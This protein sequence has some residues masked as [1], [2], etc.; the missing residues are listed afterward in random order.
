MLSS[1]GRLAIVSTDPVSGFLELDITTDILDIEFETVL[2]SDADSLQL[3]E[4]VTI[5]VQPGNE[6]RIETGSVHYRPLESTEIFTATSLYPMGVNFYATIPAQAVT[7]RGLEYFVQVEN[8]NVVRLAP[9]DAPDSLF[10]KAVEYPQSFAVTVQPNHG[11]EILA[12]TEL[13]L[14]V[15]IPIGAEF[16]NGSVSYR[17]GGA[18]T[19]SIVPIETFNQ[20]PM[21]TIPAE[22]VTERGLEYWAEVN[23]NTTRM[24]SPTSGP[25]ENPWPIQ[26]TVT[27]LSEG[28]EHKGGRYRMLSVPLQF[29]TEGHSIVSLLLDEFG[30]YD[31]FT[32]RLF[33]YS[34]ILNKNMEYSDASAPEF[35]MEP[36]KSFWM[37]SLESHQI[38]TAP[39]V[40]Q[41]IPLGVPYQLELAA[42]WNQIANPFAFP[43]AWESVQK[44]EDIGDPVAFDSSL[45]SIGEYN[46]DVPLILEPFAG[47]FLHNF[48]EDAQAITFFPIEAG[49]P[50]NVPAPKSAAPKSAA[51]KVTPLNW[52][53]T[54]RATTEDAPSDAI[55]VGVKS[56]AADDLD[57]L[58]LPKPPPAPGPWVCIGVDNSEWA[59]RAGLYRQDY[60]E[61]NSAGH[62]WNL[63]IRSETRSEEIIFD[64][65]READIPPELQIRF[66]DLQT[67]SI[68][69]PDRK[70]SGAI[71]LV[72]PGA[73]RDYHLVL[74]VGTEEYVSREIEALTTLPHTVLLDQNAPNPFNGATNI[75]FGLVEE[76][77]VGLTIYDLRGRHVLDLID[78]E[79]LSPGFHSKIWTGVDRYGKPV[80]SGV[81]IYR[82]VVDGKSLHRKMAYIQ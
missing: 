76:S 14:I 35:T 20:L 69:V 45:G 42:G 31:P 68:V 41:S 80:A 49:Q 56:N 59:K 65:W 15:D 17:I 73:K 70:D 10:S 48:A 12:G 19:F 43:V 32:W 8:S 33:R 2:F 23:T 30:N 72:S 6:V 66:V 9:P 63:A 60:R 13:K 67:G 4:A 1:D 7:E 82:L 36:G 29:E 75:R 3:G 40:G 5:F 25:E 24:T 50:D 53:L 81:Y 26:T 78:Q 61:F 39:I 38:D 64:G 16:I 47:Y 54:L 21:S 34:P 55:V 77:T 71:R 27:N 46:T 51:P 79:I 28:E 58:D 74:L 37:I 22:A 52:S 11:A 44:S 62:S 18:D 57:L